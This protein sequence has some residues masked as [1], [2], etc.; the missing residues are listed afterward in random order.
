[1][2]SNQHFSTSSNRTK[3]HQKLWMVSIGT[4]GST[5]PVSPLSPNS[6]QV[7][8]ISA[9][10]LLLSGS[11]PRR[12]VL[13]AIIP[14]PLKAEEF[15][16][17]SKDF[18]PHP[19]DIEGWTANQIV[20]FL[21]RVQLFKVPLTPELS[22][23]MG[24]TYALTKTRNV[25]LSSR[26]F[27]VGL[28]A[29]DTTVYQPTADLLGTVGRMKFVRPLYR[30]LALV[31]REL[32]LKTFEKNKVRL[33]FPLSQC[34]TTV[35]RS[36]AA[37]RSFTIQSAGAWWRRICTEN[38]GRVPVVNVDDASTTQGH[39]YSREQRSLPWVTGMINYYGL[40]S[41]KLK[42]NNSLGQTQGKD[43]TWRTVVFARHTEGVHSSVKSKLIASLCVT[44]LVGMDSRKKNPPERPSQW[45]KT[46]RKSP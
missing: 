7:W 24:K 12:Y 21:E 26:Y 22:Q 20:V 16:H 46:I 40:H 18:K 37:S 36:N 38:R 8:L 35:N 45:E 10:P 23:A 41:W 42:R 14:F 15:T 6:T 44:D 4:H 27:G 1:M 13:A 33:S 2:S 3:L 11:L 5:S 39:H 28:R 43:I 30:S 25:E 32:A 19:S 9:T 31:D 17:D 29:K 34:S